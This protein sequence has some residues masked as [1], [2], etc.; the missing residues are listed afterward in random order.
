M[1]K[2]FCMLLL[3]PSLAMAGE[4]CRKMGGQCKDACGSQEE[5]V[6]GAF[7]DCTDTQE[8]CV[9][10]QGAPEQ[11]KNGDKKESRQKVQQ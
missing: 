2:W 9:E 1:V 7:L 4:D 6:A 3:L 10:K 5:A 11:G 8:C